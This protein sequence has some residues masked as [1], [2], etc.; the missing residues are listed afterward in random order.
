[1]SKTICIVGTDTEIGKTYTCCQILHYLAQH[2]LKVCAIKPIAS[3]VSETEHGFINEDAYHLSK[4]SN[5]KLNLNTVNPICFAEAIAPHIAA[6]NQNF[7]LDI[8]SVISQ[9]QLD[10]TI[11]DYVLVEG[12]GG[13]MVPLNLEETYLDLLI[14][15]N[16][17]IILVVGI[18]LGCLNH[19]LLTYSN[20]IAAKLNVVGWVANHIETD[21]PYLQENI[22]YLRT[23]LNIPLLAKIPHQQQLQPTE[24]FFKVFTCN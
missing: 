2:G 21:M 3:G 17:P 13:I 6:K 1:M 14:K 20:L 10:T 23:K 9:N 15:W 18:K 4:A 19:A 24:D 8:A 12:V 22:D 11:C 5:I 16:Q 7:I